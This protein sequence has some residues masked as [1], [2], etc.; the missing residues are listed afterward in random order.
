M[1]IE[2]A[3]RIGSTRER[4]LAA[5]TSVPVHSIV[6][7]IPASTRLHVWILND[8]NW[9]YPDDARLWRMIIQYVLHDEPLLI[10]A[11]KI[12]PVTFHLLKAVGVRGV[13]FYS[14]LCSNQIKAETRAA[15]DILGLPHL[16]SLTAARAHA[17]RKQ[18][19]NSIEV[20]QQLPTLSSETRHVLADAE[21]R[22]FGHEER[23]TVHQLR[24]WTEQTEHTW[25]DVW[26]KTLYAWETRDRL[27]LS[28][29]TS[30]PGVDE[31]S[32]RVAKDTDPDPMSDAVWDAPPPGATNEHERLS[33]TV[34]RAGHV[35]AEV[36]RDTW[37]LLLQRMASKKGKAE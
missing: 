5:Q 2:D 30:A 1:G 10:I 22:G 31:N 34:T 13:Q 36:N 8:I 9:L 17:V 33:T 14:L 27:G 24:V 20:L 11:R 12:A 6:A 23:P 16:L 7:A 18:I 25:P 35:A 32:T 28:E 3:L 29:L 26:S 19:R 21:Q 15:A 37:D 4:R